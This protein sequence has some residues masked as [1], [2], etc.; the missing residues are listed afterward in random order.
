MH[1][2]TIDEHG[3][4]YSGPIGGLLLNWVQSY[5][6]LGVDLFLWPFM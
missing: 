3:D 6:Y 1:P 2:V 5:R 4:C